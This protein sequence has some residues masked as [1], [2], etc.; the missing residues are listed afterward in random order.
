[1]A[2]PQIQTLNDNYYKGTMGFDQF[3]L[4]ATLAACAYLAQTA[5]YDR[6]GWNASTLQLI[7][8]IVL[9]FS[10]FF[11][12]KRIESSIQTIKLN[13]AYLQLCTDYPR[14]PFPEQKGYVQTESDRSGMYYGLRNKFIL[15]SFLVFVITKVLVKYSIF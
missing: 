14:V 10:A 13:S 3:V 7:P 12:F 8:L 5:T 9:G 6:I 15:L 1:M 2:S 4:G 11:G